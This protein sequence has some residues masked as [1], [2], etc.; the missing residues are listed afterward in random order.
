MT[1][2]EVAGVSSGFSLPIIECHQVGERHQTIMGFIQKWFGFNGW[3]ELSTRGN[4]FATIAYR[5]VFVAGLAATI[6][7]YS[8]AMGGED[9]SLLYIGVVGVLWF[10]VFQFIVNLV[11]V[12]GSR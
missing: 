6:I 10:L 7:V 8:Y 12:N 5:V 4:I 1:E 3:N 2:G 11:F 9:P